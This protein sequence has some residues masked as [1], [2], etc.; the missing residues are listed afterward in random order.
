MFFFLSHNFFSTLAQHP[1]HNLEV[2][3]VLF[4]SFQLPVLPV[5]IIQQ[6]D[7]Q[8]TRL[9]PDNKAKLYR[10]SRHNN[11]LPDLDS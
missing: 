10:S 1:Q 8:T 3:V 7:P 5:D 9:Q 2:T 6:W 4:P 11:V